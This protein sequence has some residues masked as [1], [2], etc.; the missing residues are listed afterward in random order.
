M[1]LRFLL[2]F[3]EVVQSLLLQIVLWH[4]SELC[5]VHPSKISQESLAFL[6]TL[7]LS[8][9]PSLSLPLLLSLPCGEDKGT[10]TLSQL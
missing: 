1:R 7:S 8:P 5:T 9:H 4:K 2:I 10:P 6:K 3:A